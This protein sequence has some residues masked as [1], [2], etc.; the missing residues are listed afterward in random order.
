MPNDTR[1]YNKSCISYKLLKLINRFIKI[2][3]FMATQEKYIKLVE[4]NRLVDE[5]IQ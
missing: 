5:W 3:G 4:I 2:D 1:R